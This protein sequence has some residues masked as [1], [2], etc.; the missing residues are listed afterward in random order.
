MCEQSLPSA[1][2][3]Q[4]RNSLSLSFSPGARE[5]EEKI[6]APSV[7]TKERGKERRNREQEKG[8]KRLREGEGGWSGRQHPGKKKVRRKKKKA[9]KKAMN[10]SERGR[11]P[12][13]R[14]HERQ[15]EGGA[16][17]IFSNLTLFPQPLSGILLNKAGT[18]HQNGSGIRNRRGA[19]DH[20][21]SSS[22]ECCS[23]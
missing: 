16:R 19:I 22:T 20:R 1:L 15:R 17:E 9:R 7:R 5:G 2:V 6:Q 21:H 23:C 3:L 11:E 10:E 12:R 8:S 14:G 13:G 4:A 18:E